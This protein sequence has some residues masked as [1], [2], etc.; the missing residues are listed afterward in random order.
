MNKIYHYL[1][2]ISLSLIIMTNSSFAA[3]VLRVDNDQTVSISFDNR[4]TQTSSYS[5]SKT[6]NIYNDGNTTMTINSVSV[7]SPGSGISL[8]VSSRP[9]SIYAGSYG[10]VTVSIYVPSTVSTGKYTGVI[11]V[12]A[13]SA[14]SKT[15][16]LI[17]D[18]KSLIPAELGFIGEKSTTILFDRP[19]GSVS[20]FPGRIDIGLNNVGDSI[21]SIN[22]ISISSYPG[23]GIDIAISDYTKSISARSN[24][25]ASLTISAPASA[26]EGTYNGKITISTSKE[27]RY[28]TDTRSVDISVKIEHGIIMELSKSTVDFGNAAIFEQKSDYIEIRE[29]LGYKP[30]KYVTISGTEQWV[31]VSPKSI[32]NIN[33]GDSGMVNINLYFDTRAV[34]RQKYEWVYSI[35]TSNAGTQSFKVIAKNTPPD[36]IPTL[37][38]VCGQTYNSNADTREIAEKIC[39]SLKYGN[40]NQNLDVMEFIDLVSI[41]TST[42]DFLDSYMAAAASISRGDHNSA[43]EHLMKGVVS[44]KMIDAYTGKIRNSNI[45]NDV[46]YIKEKSDNLI[47]DI[48]EKEKD[49]YEAESKNDDNALQS[50]I[51]YERLSEMYGILGNQGES[52]RF[53]GLA[54]QKFD[55]H[56]KYSDSAKDA[57][58]KANAQLKDL[59]EKYL[60]R[61]GGQYIWINP[62]F[63]GRIS[64]EYNSI[65]SKY[66]GTIQDYR[67]AGE[68]GMADKTQDDLNNIRSEHKKRST[69]FFVFTGIYSLLF[70]GMLSRAAKSMVAFIRDTSETRMGDNFL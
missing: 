20:S 58:I 12:D 21:L 42:A 43:Y 44:E 57:R 39:R 13:A 11:T 32:N 2:I 65:F 55:L 67:K 30:I 68:N 66:D 5:S 36:V 49:Y 18:V 70:I 16:N 33:A 35:S 45:I 27:G 6:F 24:G 62:F 37:N 50:M 3:P 41:G 10:T 19:K 25:M 48:M 38:K 28:G 7:S 31:S 9:Y 29:T 56:N 15:M 53:D 54:K 60:S 4:F 63:Y 17:L 61:W 59:E 40:E 64:D 34:L 47:N 46:R 1:L 51:A 14:G 23:N 22:S 26:S 69:I 52:T 8:S